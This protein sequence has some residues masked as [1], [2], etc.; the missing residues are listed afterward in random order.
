MTLRR[1]F[2]DRKMSTGVRKMGALLPFSVSSKNPRRGF[3]T[4]SKYKAPDKEEM[5]NKHVKL[6]EFLIQR[7]YITDDQLQIALK[8]QKQLTNVLIGEILV[9]IGAFDSRKLFQYIKE[10]VESLDDIPDHIQVWI[11][12]REINHLVDDFEKKQDGPL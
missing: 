1:S 4:R 2:F 7:G 8:K 9:A 5:G 10:Y 3:S 6:G 12:Q 11:S